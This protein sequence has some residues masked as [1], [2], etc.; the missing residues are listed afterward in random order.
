MSCTKVPIVQYRLYLLLTYSDIDRK[1]YELP[2]PS[3]ETDLTVY[4]LFLGLLT[5]HSVWVMI[6]MFNV[7]I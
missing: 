7:F 3:V 5:I 2:L 1:D 6:K 4:T